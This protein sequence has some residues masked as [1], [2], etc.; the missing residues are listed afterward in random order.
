[1]IV[2]LLLLAVLASVVGLAGPVRAA[3]PEPAAPLVMP[4]DTELA[5]RLGFL[6]ERLEAQRPTALTWQYGW[7]GFY[8]VSLARNTVYAARAD[9]GDQRV[10]GIVDAAKS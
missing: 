2:R 1:M 8:L 9:D 7:T 10:R 6:E 5:A 3:A 4:T